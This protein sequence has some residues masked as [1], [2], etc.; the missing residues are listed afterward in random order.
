MSGCCHWWKWCGRNPRHCFAAGGVR[1]EVVPGRPG[2]VGRGHGRRRAEA[3]RRGAMSRGGFLLWLISSMPWIRS[4]ARRWN[5]NGAGGT[6]AIRIAR[7]SRRAK[8]NPASS[9]R[10]PQ[11]TP[12]FW[13]QTTC[14]DAAAR[15][16]THRS[17]RRRAAPPTAEVMD[18][19]CRLSKSA[20]FVRVVDGGQ[21]RL[22]VW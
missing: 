18:L 10:P 13:F 17:T 7:G 12:G 15:G 11:R 14:G 19:W 2:R 8:I 22:T 3:K 4:G 9:S 1:T 6:D 20:S 5:C 16:T 21:L